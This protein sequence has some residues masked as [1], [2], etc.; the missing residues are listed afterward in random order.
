MTDDAL[1][2]L[3]QSIDALRRDVQDLRRGQQ[4]LHRAL[5]SHQQRL[6][7]RLSVTRDVSQALVTASHAELLE[8][9]EAIAATLDAHRHQLEDLE[10]DVDLL[11]DNERT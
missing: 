5:A 6:D 11:F 3:C 9:L 4:R 8:H 7:H 10:R 2:R 1:S